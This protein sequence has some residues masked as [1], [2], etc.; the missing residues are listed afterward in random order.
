MKGGGVWG[1]EN[2]PIGEKKKKYIYIYILNI[3]NFF[4]K[5]KKKMRR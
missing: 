1:E 4:I 3:V 5:Q 2:Q